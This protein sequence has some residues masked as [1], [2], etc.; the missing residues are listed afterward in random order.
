[1]SKNKKGMPRKIRLFQSDEPD[2]KKISEKTGLS[3]VD[4]LSLACAA[5]I[6]AIKE[7]DYKINLPLKFKVDLGANLSSAEIAAIASMPHAEKIAHEIAAKK[8]Q[9]EQPTLSKQK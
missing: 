1:M 5:G 7:N 6:Q 9:A 3:E 8:R 4:I 2:I